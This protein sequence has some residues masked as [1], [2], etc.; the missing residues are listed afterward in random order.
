MPNH[1]VE[2]TRIVTEKG[3]LHLDEPV[4]LRSGV[5]SSDFVDV[6][7][8]LADG[9][10]LEL[11]CRAMAE[12]ATDELGIEFDAVGGMT[13]GADQFAYGIAIVAGKRWFVVRKEP[14]GRGTNKRVEGADVGPGVRVLLVEDAVSL[15]GSIRDA[16]EVVR[17]T[18]ATVAAAMTLVD[19]SD[20]IAPF[21]R[22]QGVP[23]KAI[24]TYRDLGIEPLRDGLAV[25]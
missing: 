1:R 8:A 2:L 21:F 14:K 9:A 19:R 17:E 6:K 23:Y 12:A 5:M 10:D 15:G 22:E 20:A 3:L 18:G 11:A 7:Q 16:Y 4:R 25:P 24:L 13:M